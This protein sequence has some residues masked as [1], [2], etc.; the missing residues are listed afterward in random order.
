MSDNPQVLQLLTDALESNRT[1][2]E[3][4]E[5]WPELLPEVRLRWEE[6]RRLSG[7]I[8]LFFPLSGEV[9]SDATGRFGFGAGPPSGEIRFRKYPAM[10]SARRLAAAGWVWSIGRIT[11]GSTG[12]LH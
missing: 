10:N 8:A 11:R 2:D 3:V 4:C 6:C 5:Q 12:R 1:P 7:A 9:L